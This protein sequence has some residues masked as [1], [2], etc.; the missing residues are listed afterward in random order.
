ADLHWCQTNTWSTWRGIFELKNVP[1]VN[2]LEQ[3]IRNQQSIF[4]VDVAPTMGFAWPRGTWQLCG[5]RYQFRPR[6][7]SPQW[8]RPTKRARRFHY[9]SFDKFGDGPPRLSGPRLHQLRR[10]LT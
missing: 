6:E 1:H 9:R 2:A 7:A 10:S 5:A 4:R 3:R 8:Y